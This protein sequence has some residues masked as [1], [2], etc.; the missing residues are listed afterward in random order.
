MKIGLD[1]PSDT[2][3]EDDYS[4]IEFIAPPPYNPKMNY[5]EL[6]WKSYTD[7]ER[8]MGEIQNL[9]LENQQVQSQIL[10]LQDFYESN[11]LPKMFAFPEQYVTRMI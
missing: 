8:I 7:N 9:S 2:D 1:S 3:S 4:E 11:L 5:F 6:Y 10:N